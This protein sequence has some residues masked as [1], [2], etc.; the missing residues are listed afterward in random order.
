MTATP[1][2]TRDVL[3]QDEAE[4]RAGRVSHAS[5]ELHIDLARGANG[6]RG[7]V[8]LRFQLAGAGDLLLDFRGKEIELLELNGDPAEPAWDGY[9]LTLPGD[10]LRAHNTVRVVYENDYDH[11]GDGFH[12][13]IDPEDGEE[14]LYTNFEPYAAHRLFPCFDQPDIKADYTLTVTAP[15][16]WEL[17]ANSLELTVEKLDDGRILHQFKKTE[18]FSSYLFALIAGPYHTFRD[19]HRGIPLGFF[20]RRSLVQHVDIDELWQV[21]KQGLDFYSSFFDYAYPFTKYDQVFVPE[22]NAGAM[23]NV[24]AVTHNEYLVFRDPPTETQR[25]QRANVLLHEMAHMWFGNLVT[26]RWWNDLWLNESFA[27]YMAHVA[28][29]E[30]TRFETAWQEF[31][32]RKAWAYRQDQLATTHPI[33]GQVADTD[34]T[35]LNFDGITYAKG[36]AVIKQLVAAMQIDGFRDA[37]RRYFRR[38]AFGNT[39]LAQ[40][41]EALQEG[42][43]RDLHEWA[44][45]WLE[46]PSL[47]TVAAS[48]ELD[49]ERMSAMRIT[50]TA[51][52]DYP[53]LRPH[54]M[55]IA[56]VREEGGGLVVD[57]LPVEIDGAEAEVPGAAGRPAPAMVVPNHNDHA[58]VKVALDPASLQ[59]LR[60]NLQRV[61]DPLLRQLIWQALWNMVRDQQLTS[62][63]YLDLA[64]SKVSAERDEELIE[65]ILGNV[66]AAIARYVPDERREAL[67]H[68]LSEVAWEALNGAPAGDLQIIWARALI[69]LA[70]SHEDIERCG[71]LADGDLSVQGLTVDQDMRWD[72]AV[73]YVAYGLANGRERLGA[74]RE[75]DP[76]DRGQRAALRGEVSEP[77]AGKKA[78]AWQR[79]HE[80]GEQAYGSLHLTAAAMSGFHWWTQRDLLDPYVERFFEQLPEV[81]EQR[82]HEFARSYFGALFP[83]HRVEGAVLERGERLLE[84]VGDRLPLLTRTLREANDDLDRAIKCRAFAGS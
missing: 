83:G 77:D 7:H 22:F 57:S 14:Y 21:T 35:L 2:T 73:R 81:F 60:G 64:A 16:Q 32:R 79:F 55:D 68:R 59:F 17:I 33:A 56:V 69:A 47:N 84:E 24:G 11:G 3:T 50:Q 49:G 29:D 12:Q 71:R 27:E 75:R 19:R 4:A 46:T 53:T 43:G 52:E 42:V 34:E 78:A 80:Q 74:E 72:I 25:S 10:A 20:C 48:W 40:F 18:P 23:E 8:T 65:A 58:F 45:V 28:T 36:A 1:A 66:Q 62:F 30:A 70:I 44:H 51:P 38:H 15:P 31:N 13:F 37:M 9:R 5:Y 63:D 61:D 26:M 76:S 82:D 6:Y 67:A 39:T 54:Y 41:L